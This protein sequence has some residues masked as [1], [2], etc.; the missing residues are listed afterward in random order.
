[1][2]VPEIEGSDRQFDSPGF[3]LRE[4]EHVVDDREQVLAGRV[5][6]VQ[7]IEGLEI[8]GIL[9]FLDEHLAVTEDCVQ[10]SAQFVAHVRQERTLGAV[11]LLGQVFGVAQAL[12]S[13]GDPFLE[14]VVE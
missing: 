7:L 13:L 11:G 10:R 12:A 9:A 8:V 1:M 14:V 6:L 4:V 2:H 5:D 3:D